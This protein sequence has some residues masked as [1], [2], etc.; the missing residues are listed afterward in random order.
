MTEQEWQERCMITSTKGRI[1]K[2][3]EIRK[4]AADKLR[5]LL[6]DTAPLLRRTA[7][8]LV[9]DDPAF[10]RPRTGMVPARVIEDSSME[11]YLNLT[12]PDRHAATSALL[13]SLKGG[14]RE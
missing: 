7:V 9:L 11:A 3:S 6:P 12:I 5:A 14:R 10:M 4:R 2:R 8:Q 13:G 1:W